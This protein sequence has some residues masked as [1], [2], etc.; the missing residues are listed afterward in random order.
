M[1]SVY[2]A[3]SGE[4]LAVVDD[5]EGKTAKE[6][7]RS[8]AAQVG[9]SRFRQRLWTDDWSHEIQDDDVFTSYLVKVQL[10]VMDFLPPEA[11]E[12]RRMIAASR[13]NDLPALEALLQGP[14]TPRL[15][16]F[17]GRTPLH[18]AAGNGHVESMRL[19]LEAGAVR[20]ARDTSPEGSTPLL[21]A[22]SRGHVEVVR[23]LIEAGVDYDEATTGGA[24]PLYIAAWKGHVEVV[25]LLIEAGVDCNKARTDN[26]LTPLYIAAQNG[27]VKVVR[28]LL[29][30][31]VDYDKAKTDDGTTPLY[32]AAQEGHVE[33]VRL[34]LQAGVDSDKARTDDGATPFFIAA[35]Y[36]H[37][38]VVRLLERTARPKLTLEQHRCLSQLRMAMS[39]LF[40]SSNITASDKFVTHARH[41]REKDSD[42]E[43]E[44]EAL[45]CRCLATREATLGAQHLHTLT[46]M[47][48]FAVLLEEHGKLEQVR[49][50]GCCIGART[51]QAH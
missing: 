51:S 42:D 12:E 43:S 41:P 16:D 2:F 19:L 35:Q 17:S 37:V 24:T 45:Y 44:A 23:F 3:V 29:E 34:L 33:V 36:G 18:H 50:M 5:Y 40:A 26:G 28:S 22:V 14:R 32:I 11:E 6:V 15:T 47:S 8:L 27:D 38:E 9:V 39:M 48:N 31:G 4:A 46:S 10:V 25:H 7:K 13:D 21:L 1:C 30:A 20:D 49:A